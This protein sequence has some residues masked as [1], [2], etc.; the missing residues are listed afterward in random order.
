M[1]GSKTAFIFARGGS[2]GVPRKNIRPL[3]GRP[4]IAYAI[5]TAL[6]SKLIDRVVVSTDD[7]EIAD[8][9]K[10]WGAEVP[11]MRPAILASDDAPEWLSWQHAI[12]ALQ[13]E[14]SAFRLGLFVSVPVTSPLRAVEDLDAVIR[15]FDPATTDAVISIRAAQRNPYFNMVRIDPDGYARIV[16]A[17]EAGP[18]R[19][20]SAPVVFDM[21]TV[22]YVA[23]PEYV[24]TSP[25]F[26]QGR[27][28]AV[29][30]P[31]ERAMDIDSELDMEIAEFL[32]QRQH[33]L[34]T[35][36]PR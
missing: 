7:A 16:I 36:K 23:A 19:R 18:T 1:T 4:M 33:R 14:D 13:E 30:I 29:E 22:A 32:M 9:A 27:I 26:F 10:S 24:L 2:K 17:P 12:R 8:V 28:R 6:Q 34:T 5:E 15:A 35:P 25:S 3:A 11:F 31:V 21:T 20:Q